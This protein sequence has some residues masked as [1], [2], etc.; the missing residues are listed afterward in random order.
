MPV[1]AMSLGVVLLMC[2]LSAYFV[3]RYSHVTAKLVNEVLT[4]DSKQD[5]IKKNVVAVILNIIAIVTAIFSVYIAYGIYF[6]VL[7]LFATP[8]KLEIKLRSSSK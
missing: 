5:G 3:R 4:E 6:T 2:S 7:A 8:Q 1:A